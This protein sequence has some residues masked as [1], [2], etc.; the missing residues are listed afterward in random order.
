MAFVTPVVEH[1]LEQ[2]TITPATSHFD[3]HIQ[4]WVNAK[5]NL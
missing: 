5:H 3:E 1:W 2:E 4:K